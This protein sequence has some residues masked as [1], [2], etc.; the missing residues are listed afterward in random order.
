MFSRDR[1]GLSTRAGAERKPAGSAAGTPYLL[2]R[3]MTAQ[4]LGFD[5]RTRN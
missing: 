3:D 4:A 2:D 5:D 1:A